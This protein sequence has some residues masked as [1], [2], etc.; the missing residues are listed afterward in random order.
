MSSGF[1]LL[2]ALATLGV[3]ALA[4]FAAWRRASSLARR[5]AAST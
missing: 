4:V 1:A 2:G 3:A 5:P